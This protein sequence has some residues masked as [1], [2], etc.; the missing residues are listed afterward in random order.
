VK[1]R[2]GPEVV[3]RCRGLSDELRAALARLPQDDADPVVVEAVW[4]GEGLGTLFW[5]LNLAELPPYDHPFDHARLLELPVERPRLRDDGELES[6]R[7]TARL[8][9]WRAR[10]T[11]LEGDP[12]FELPPPWTSCQE[13]VASVA[14]RGH[15]HG[16][17]PEP[18][19]DDFPALGFVY[20]WAT[21]RELG[22]L[23]S[24]A[25]ERHRALSWLC[26]S[27]RDWDDVSLDT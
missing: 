17:L 16:L 2:H 23:R 11:D 24:I 27:G 18:L 10:M 3:D 15:E 8:W 4:R 19:G 9:H 5:A 21:P 26:D 22:E 7:E 12:S 13:L 6:A 20:R 25:Y 1:I 14:A